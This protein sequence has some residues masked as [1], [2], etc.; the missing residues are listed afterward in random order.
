MGSPPHPDLQC[1]ILLSLCFSSRFSGDVRWHGRSPLGSSL[2][3]FLPRP[4]TKNSPLL[5]GL[6]DRP[7]DGDIHYPTTSAFVPRP[8]SRGPASPSRPSL[9]PLVVAVRPRW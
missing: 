1:H 5:A 9:P 7:V 6:F 8:G 4:E 3:C 2:P